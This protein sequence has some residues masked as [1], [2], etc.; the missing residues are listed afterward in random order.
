[1]TDARK[2][3]RAAYE[4]MIDPAYEEDDIDILERALTEFA[5]A[6]GEDLKAYGQALD[7]AR[8]EARDAIAELMQKARRDDSLVN[9]LWTS[10][11]AADFIRALTGDQLKKQP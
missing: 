6:H 3:A 11:G 1:M 9:D 2:A 7:Y 8:L 5:A 4:K 10:L